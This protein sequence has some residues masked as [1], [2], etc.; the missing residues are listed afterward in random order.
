MKSVNIYA[1]YRR[2]LEAYELHYDIR[3]RVSLGLWGSVGSSI[4]WDIDTQLWRGL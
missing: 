3:K 1:E 4:Q 2:R